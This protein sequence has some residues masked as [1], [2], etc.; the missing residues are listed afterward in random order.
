M[1]DHPPPLSTRVRRLA[2]AAVALAGTFAALQSVYGSTLLA[3]GVVLA[4][5]ALAA[6][7]VR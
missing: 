5:L 4:I 3:A 6:L 1:S 7:G 2:A